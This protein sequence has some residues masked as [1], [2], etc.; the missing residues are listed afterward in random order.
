METRNLKHVAHGGIDMEINHP[1]LGWIPFT[2][3]PDDP[4][5]GAELHAKALAGDF[6]PIAEYAEPPPQIPQVVSPF[7]AKAALDSWQM[8]DTVEAMMADPAT[9]RITRM[10]WQE[11]QE[12]RRTSPTV[13]QMGAAL[14]LTD[15]Q[16]DELFVIA[17]GISA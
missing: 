16:L 2:A 4:G 13:L 7:Q 5:L 3:A 8:L 6:G 14:G 1:A 9:P 11:A 15:A 10:A 12:F 17:A